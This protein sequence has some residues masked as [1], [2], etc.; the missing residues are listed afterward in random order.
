MLSPTYFCEQSRRRKRLTTP[1]TKKISTN[2]IPAS[3]AVFD[4]A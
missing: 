3:E 1:S 2:S 4:E